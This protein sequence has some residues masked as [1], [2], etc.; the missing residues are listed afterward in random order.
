MEEG[1]RRRRGGGEEEAR[2]RRGFLPLVL[3]APAASHGLE[4]EQQHGESGNSSLVPGSGQVSADA[5]GFLCV[6]V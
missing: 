2:R 6:S 5:G 1:R 4:R 3:P